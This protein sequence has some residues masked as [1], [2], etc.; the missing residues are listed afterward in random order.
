MPLS[1]T[2]PVKSTAVAPKKVP[3][4]KKVAAVK[5]PSPNILTGEEFIKKFGGLP[6]LEY[7]TTEAMR[8]K[9]GVVNMGVMHETSRNNQL[10]LRKMDADK[11]LSLYRSD[12]TMFDMYFSYYEEAFGYSGYY[13]E[14]DADIVELLIEKYESRYGAIR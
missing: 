1:R 2:E 12:P 10:K 14:N 6:P 5:T 9:K 4:Q 8:F 3:V 13:A 11:L 7:P